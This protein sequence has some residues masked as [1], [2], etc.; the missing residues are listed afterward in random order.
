M[1]TNKSLQRQG[2]IAKT[3]RQLGASFQTVRT[4][5]NI[6]NRFWKN[7]PNGYEMR[8]DEKKKECT[9]STAKDKLP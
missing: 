3:E 5:I 1:S 8:W 9:V 2:L 6:K 7:L 4:R